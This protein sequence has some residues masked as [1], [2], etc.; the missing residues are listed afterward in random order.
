M[1]APRSTNEL[2]TPV[3]FLTRSSAVDAAGAPLETWSKVLPTIYAKEETGAASDG[4]V[5]DQMASFSRVVF[6]IRNRP[7]IS[8]TMRARRNGQVFEVKAVDVFRRR[9]WLRLE[10]EKVNDG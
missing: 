7:G 8:N 1:A 5:A 6:W 4:E 10:C 2:D 9:E 3:E